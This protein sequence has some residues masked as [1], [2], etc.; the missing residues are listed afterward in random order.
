MPVPAD[1]QVYAACRCRLDE[2]IIGGVVFHNVEGVQRDDIL[3]LRQKQRVKIIYFF[4][5]DFKLL[6]LHFK[7]YIEPIE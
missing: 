4:R 5:F 1:N 7:N 2:H 3:R 6:T